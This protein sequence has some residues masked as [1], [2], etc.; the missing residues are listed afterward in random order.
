MFDLFKL[1][2]TICDIKYKK[3]EAVLLLVVLEYL[4]D[5]FAFHE[6]FTSEN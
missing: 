4:S 1:L 2:N 3:I 5:T 6:Y